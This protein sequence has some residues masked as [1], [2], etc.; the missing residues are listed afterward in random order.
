MSDRIALAKIETC[1]SRDQVVKQ[2]KAVA[3]KWQET[4]DEEGQ[5]LV[6]LEASV[7]LLLY[8][9]TIA[10]GLDYQEQAKVFRYDLFS[11]KLEVGDPITISV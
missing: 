5:S 7:G 3:T 4:A 9:I 2:L 11:V 1:L 8:D 6:E 10:L